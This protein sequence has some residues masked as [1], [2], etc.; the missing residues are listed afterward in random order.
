MIDEVTILEH[1]FGEDFFEISTN[2]KAQMDQVMLNFLM[3][4]KSYKI[5]HAIVYY[6]VEEIQ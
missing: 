6:K 2:H 4:I 3:E 5:L 1:S